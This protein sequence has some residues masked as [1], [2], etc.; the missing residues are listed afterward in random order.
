MCS[1]VKALPAWGAGS[2]ILFIYFPR[3][4]GGGLGGLP[5]RRRADGWTPGG[6]ARARRSST[7]RCRKDGKVNSARGAII[8]LTTKSFTPPEAMSELFYFN[9]VDSHSLRTATEPAQPSCWGAGQGTRVNPPPHRPRSNETTPKHLFR[10]FR[11]RKD[12]VPLPW[13]F[14]SHAELVA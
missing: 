6:R 9:F 11:G 5:L 2:G 8:I 12:P 10:L 7:T 4:P 1:H 14:R 13:L 3:R